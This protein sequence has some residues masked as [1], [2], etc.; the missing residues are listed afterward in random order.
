M[1]EPII[2]K[3]TEFA[4]LLKEYNAGNTESFDKMVA[5]ISKNLH[6]LIE[7]KYRKLDLEVINL[8]VKDQ[9]K[10]EINKHNNESISHYYRFVQLRVYERLAH[11][12][13]IQTK[14]NSYRVTKV[15]LDENNL[16]KETEERLK[17]MKD[18]RT[19][20]TVWKYY[21]LLEEYKQGLTQSEYIDKTYA[22]TREPLLDYVNK[23]N[24][25]NLLEI[26]DIEDAIYDVVEKRVKKEFTTG[27]PIDEYYKLIIVLKRSLVI[28]LE[29]EQVKREKL[30]FND[31]KQCVIEPLTSHKEDLTY[32]EPVDFVLKE[33]QKQYL[34]K[35]LDKLPERSKKILT[36]RFFENM[37]RE[38]I[39]NIVKISRE[40][41]LQIEKKALKK[42]YEI[43]INDES[44]SLQFDKYL[45]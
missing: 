18:R 22:I 12:G 5:I 14:R 26:D 16:V 15:V 9:L 31:D 27:K 28:V 25:W 23:N 6:E 35:I 38:K 3:Q 7:S 42:L 19:T 41:V 32:P 4:K 45:D 24:K 8:L 29:N 40:R 11:W 1:V 37:P 13:V 34:L 2:L 20:D 33:E 44:L 17:C 30:Y 10:K 39:G 21:K 36:L 43:V